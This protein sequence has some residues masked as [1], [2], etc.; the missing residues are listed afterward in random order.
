M[1]K[2]IRQPTGYLWK[3]VQERGRTDWYMNAKEAQKH[4]IANFI[5]IPALRTS[6]RV[7]MVLE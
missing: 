1:E 3:M 4:N 7:E 2:N 6:V 5:K